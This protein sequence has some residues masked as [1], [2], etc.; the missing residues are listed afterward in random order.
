[1]IP[2]RGFDRTPLAIGHY[3]GHLA[4]GARDPPHLCQ[5]D[6]TAPGAGGTEEGHILGLAG[7]HQFVII[8]IAQNEVI[9]VPME[10]E[11]RLA[12]IFT[13]RELLLE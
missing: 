4:S 10:N 7:N 5:R 12:E 9:R 13:N 2:A 3:Q 11:S 8:A 1:M 6:R